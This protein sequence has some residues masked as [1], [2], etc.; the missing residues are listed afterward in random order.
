MALTL[1]M[2]FNTENGKTM[3][4]SISEPKDDLTPAEVSNV[5]Q[6]II[7]QDVFHYEGFSL[8]GINQARVI[9]RNISEIALS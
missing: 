5:M 4:I 9:E 7:D 3:T 8:I 2:K 6:T 1:E